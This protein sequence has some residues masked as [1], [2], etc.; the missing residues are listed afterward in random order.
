MRPDT[1]REAEGRAAEP[2]R[3]ELA[4]PG[5]DQYLRAEDEDAGNE[6]GGVEQELVLDLDAEHGEEDGGQ[7]EPE[8]HD[9][10]GAVLVGQ[11]AGHDQPH[12]GADVQHQQQDQSGAHGVPGGGHELRQ[13]RVQAVHQQEPH[14]RRHGDAQRH[15]R[16]GL[17]GEVAEAGAVPGFARWQQGRR[18]GL[19]FG[20]RDSD[21]AVRP[22][23]RVLLGG[24]V[25]LCSRSGCTEG[26]LAVF[27]VDRGQGLRKPEPQERH[28]HES[29][30][31]AHH[32][33]DPPVRHHQDGQERGGHG[34]HVVAGHGPRGGLP[35]GAGRGVVVH[36]RQGRGKAGARDPRPRGGGRCRT[37][38]RS[39]RTP[40]RW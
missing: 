6:D 21:G 11:D 31:A 32:E 3:E 12:H 38:R 35:G 4:D 1:R 13:P 10:L 33:H 14:E 18:R 20:R 7:A 26:P 15:Q 40:R 29:G 39:G 2:G 19:G 23:G 34:A 37:W 36:V 24:C 30:H 28:Q 17:L 5:V 8:Q 27:R 25:F 9:L 22:R 16:I